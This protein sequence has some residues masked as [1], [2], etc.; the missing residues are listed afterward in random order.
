MKSMSF[1]YSIYQLY[2]SCFTLQKH[3]NK[4]DYTSMNPLF[5]YLPVV[6][7]EMIFPYREYKVRKEKSLGQL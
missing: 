5:I 4:I 7:R 1:W 2:V 6:V 3:S